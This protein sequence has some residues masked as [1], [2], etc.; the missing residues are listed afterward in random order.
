MYEISV[1]IPAYNEETR[2][3]ETLKSLRQFAEKNTG[4]LKFKEVLV[5]DDGSKD[6]TEHVLLRTEKDWSELKHFS[7]SVNQG[8]GAAVH[9]G[10]REAASEY[11]LIADADMA[12]PWEEA[13]KLI[14][15]I[16]NNDLVMGSRALPESDIIVRQHW[17]RQNLGKT[18][19]K[20]IRL[21]IGLPFKDT[22]CGFKLLRNDFLFRTTVLP[23]LKVSRFAWDVELIL[24]MMKHHRTIKEVGVRWRHQ[25]Q[26]HVRILKDSFEMLWTVWKLRRR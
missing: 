7:F 23:H 4:E 16:H 3:P 19:N 13:F 24:L 20:I 10:L 25:E 5:V 8:K 12:T 17:L 22:Q 6:A 15:E 11:V 26:S 14:N 2:L 18:F 21:F 9:K 1:V